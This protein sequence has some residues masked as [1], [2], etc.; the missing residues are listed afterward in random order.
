MTG[1]LLKAYWRE[2]RTS[3][4]RLPVWLP[5]TVMELG[6]IG[7]L[8]EGGWTKATDLGALG[9]PVT[10]RGEG[11]AAD[12]DY[13]SGAE[14]SL[15]TRVSGQLPDAAGAPVSG[16][17]G[18]VV[19][20]RR[21]GAF[22]LKSHA[23][24]VHRIDNLDAVEKAVIALHTRLRWNPDWVIV[25]EVARGGPSITV[26]SKEA[27]A[28][29]VLDLGLAVTGAGVDL[30]AARTG[31]R[32]SHRSRDAWASVTT[33]ESTVLWR[34]RYVNE[35]WFGRTTVRERGEDGPAGPAP[36][37]STPPSL[38][39]SAD[40]GPYLADVEDLDEILPL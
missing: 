5:G 25:T 36:A 39:R 12:Y 20:F 26:I 27:G 33:E 17:G 16:G 19:D 40:G 37:W 21:S 32:F 30:A 28:Q 9:I 31:M 34:G 7:V 3:F 11:A 14:V 35:G 15:T 22:I 10:R 2:S 24:R 4:S 38:P 18:L 8:G 29:S 1:S 13:S 6:D 23:V